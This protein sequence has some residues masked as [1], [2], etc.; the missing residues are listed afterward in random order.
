MLIAKI[1]LIYIAVGLVYE[2]IEELGEKIAEGKKDYEDFMQESEL[3]PRIYE[4]LIKR[5]GYAMMW[6]FSIVVILITIVHGIMFLVETIVDKRN[7]ERYRNSE[8][9]Q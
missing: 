8:D 5:L 3:T 1:V 4:P 6:P 2:L 9:K 7:N